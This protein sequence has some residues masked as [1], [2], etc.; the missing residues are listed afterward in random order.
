MVEEDERKQNPLSKQQTKGDGF[1]IEV[2]AEELLDYDDDQPQEDIVTA[3][4][5]A[6]QHSSDEEEVVALGESAADQSNNIAKMFD[7]LSEDE[8]MKI[9]QLKSF[10]HKLFDARFKN[11][12][13]GKN[14]GRRKSSMLSPTKTPVQAGNDISN[15]RMVKSPSDTTIYAPAV[16]RFQQPL[17]EQ[18]QQQPQICHLTNNLHDVCHDNLTDQVANFVEQIRLETDQQEQNRDDD[19]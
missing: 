7:N 2:D 14:E 10:V 18:E 6:Q 3:E 4:T 17:V 15:R 19:V 1:V 5:Q 8:L 9:P 11:S 13:D 16:N 12:P